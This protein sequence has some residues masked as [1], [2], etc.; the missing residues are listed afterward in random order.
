M[1]WRGDAAGGRKM[2][3]TCLPALDPLKPEGRH[4]KTVTIAGE[5][6]TLVCKHQTG[7]SAHYAQHISGA[8]IVFWAKKHLARSSEKKKKKIGAEPMS[9][10]A[11]NG[12]GSFKTNSHQGLTRGLPQDK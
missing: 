10:P 9:I 6:V 3:A 4:G 7:R 8:D 11:V 1:R 5:H 12:R 2:G